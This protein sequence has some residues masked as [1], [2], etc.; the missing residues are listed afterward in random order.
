MSRPE[1]IAP[2][3]VFYNDDEARKYAANSR[4]ANLQC[5][6]AQRCLELILLPDEPC[7]LL[8]IGCGSGMSG[9]AISDAGHM[10]LG[11]DISP[12]MLTVAKERGCEGDIMQAD[13]GQEMRFRPGT[14]DGAISVSVLQWLCNVD[15]KGHEPYKRLKTFFQSLSNCLKPGARACLQFYPETPGQVE[16]ITSAAMRSGFGGGMVVDYPHSAKAKKHYLVLY[17]GFSGNVVLPKG[18]TGDEEDV[19]QVEKRE[20]V[21]NTRKGKASKKG[22]VKDRILKKKESQRRR[23]MDVRSDTKYTARPRK[24]KF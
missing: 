18:L 7:L 10:W 11:F 9:Q 6:L 23:G 4:M 24:G 15:R 20:R 21:S 8:D 2:P 22:S 14:F 19:V 12:S 13:A 16:M 3:E 1:H 17:A 5:E